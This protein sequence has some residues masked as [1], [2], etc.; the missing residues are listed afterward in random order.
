VSLDMRPGQMTAF[1][2]SSGSGKSTLMNLVLGFHRPQHGRI[3]FDG[4]DMRELDMRTL[5]RFFAVVPQEPVL[6]S[7]TVRE[8]VAY[9]LPL[10]TDAQ[11][12]TALEVANAWEFV[13]KL[14]GGWNARVGERGGSLS[15]GQRQ[16]LAIA[17]AV[18]RN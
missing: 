11:L 13:H 7:G 9:G 6:V 12:R 8:N 14:P 15:G 5:R 16:R 1:V 4:Q 2:G 10:T 3:L 18:L 17:R